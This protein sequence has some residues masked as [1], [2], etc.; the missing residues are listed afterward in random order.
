MTSR[1]TRTKTKTEPDRVESLLAFGLGSNVGD[2]KALLLWAIERL[3]EFYGPL[4]IAP[5]YRTTPISP[6]PQADFF[7]T[8]VLATLPAVGGLDPRQV[9]DQAKELERL[10]GRRD[11]ER[12]GPR[13]LDIDLLL[14]GDLVRT[15]DD[16]SSA[17]TSAG[18]NP[19]RRLT[20]P[21]PRM[22]RR[23]FVLAPLNDLAPRLLIPPD[24]AVVAELLAALGS[25]QP[26]ELIGWRPQ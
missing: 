9:L 16:R 14:F 8:V 20:L 4:K 1:T 21:H 7:N 13:P 6:I 12:D 18:G 17:P 11:G 24:G 26:V 10:A 3:R 15:D 25:E 2:S 23:R 19:D 22:R 5:L